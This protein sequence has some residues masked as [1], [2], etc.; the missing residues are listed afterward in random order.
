MN[1]PLQLVFDELTVKQLCT[2]KAHYT[3]GYFGLY[4][5]NYKLYYLT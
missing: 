3:K 2:R 1:F 4:L 5:A